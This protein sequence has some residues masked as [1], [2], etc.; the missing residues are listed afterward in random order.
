MA[1]Q[2]R[3]VR[4]FIS[5]TFR[6]M[7]A[8]RDHLVRFVF[9]RLREQ[10]LP[11]RIHLVDVDLRWGVTGEQDACEVCREIIDECRPRFLCMLGGRYGTIPEGR[12]L[13][14]T[15]DEVHFGILDADREKLYGL[16]HFR[17]GAATEKMDAPSPGSVREPRHSEKA[18]KLARLKRGIRAA[19]CKPFLY[20][21]R[22]D[23]E[24]QRLL[25][26][27]AFGDRVGR[28][29]LATIDDEF[30]VEPPAQLD[31][32]AEENAAMEAFVE[33]RGERF[34]L[35]SREAALE[36]LLAHAGATGGNGYVCLTGA[37]GS[38][39]SALLAHLS[40]HPTL[41]AQP[42]ILLIRHFVGAS[43]GSTDV[44]RTLRRLCHEL[45]AGCPDI[46]AE[47]PDDPE[48]LRAALAGFLRHA[49]ASR[50]V[51]ILLDG[52]D[53][54]DPASHSA[55]LHW[56][57]QDLPQGA[58]VI[59]SALD[60][61]ALE[62]LRRLC[63]PRE[64]ELKP[65]TA[66]D[67]GA[68][69]EQFRRRY[70]KQF[71]PDQRAA[72]LAKTDAGTPLYLL[73][74]LEELRTL[75]TYEEIA[76]RIAGLPATTQELFAWILKRLENDDGFRDAAGRRVGRELVSR[77]A[78]LLGASR[79]GLSHH[80]L[81]DLLDPGDPQG[82]VAAL[83]HLL[84]PYLMR[85]GELLD[86][87][88]GQLKDAVGKRY[89]SDEDERRQ[90]HKAIADY[91]ETRWRDAD[92]HALNELP[93]HL[94]KLGDLPL[95]SR[96]VRTGFLE[97]K[98]DALGDA[99]SL[100]D[101]WSI[102]SVLAK[103]G[104]AWWD[105]L[106]ACANSYCSLAE[107]VR[108]TSGTIEAAIR[109]GDVPRAMAILEAEKDD[110]HKGPVAL[111]AS[112]LLAN[113]GHEAAAEQLRDWAVDI[114]R[115]SSYSQTQFGS[116][117]L[118]YALLSE[119]EAARSQVPWAQYAKD[120]LGDELPPMAASESR[121]PEAPTRE[122]VP[123]RYVL[124][125]WLASHNWGRLTFVPI[126]G[127]S[128]F[129]VMLAVH[130]VWNMPFV[131]PTQW[132]SFWDAGTRIVI[133]ILAALIPTWLVRIGL[134]KV[135]A[136]VLKAKLPRLRELL[137]GLAGGFELAAPHRQLV[138]AARVARFQY[139]LHEAVGQHAGDDIGASVVARMM[140]NC[141]RADD[142]ARLIWE[143]TGMGTLACGAVVHELL[144]LDP[145]RRKV[146]LTQVLR[147]PQLAKDKK[148]LFRIFDGAGSCDLDPAVL[149]Q[150]LRNC[151]VRDF[152]GIVAALRRLPRRCLARA[153]LAGAALE[154]RERNN[155]KG[156]LARFHLLRR[157]LGRFRNICLRAIPQALGPT[158]PVW[159]LVLYTPSILLVA[160]WVP[161][162]ALGMLLAL[163]VILGLPDIISQGCDPYGIAR[164]SRRG[165][166]SKRAEDIE[167]AIQ[168]PGGGLLALKA[169]RRIAFTLLARE[170]IIRGR[171]DPE[172]HSPYLRRFME[173]LVPVLLRQG[174]L[175][176]RGEAV[177]MAMADRRLLNAALDGARLI[178]FN[179]ENRVFGETDH[180]RQL[181]ASLPLPVW[182]NLALM[183]AL[184]AS[185]TLLWLTTLMTVAPVA[186]AGSLRS[187][188]FW[189]VL[190]FCIGLVIMQHIWRKGMPPVITA[191]VICGG[192]AAC[193]AVVA[194]ST[195]WAIAVWGVDV[196]LGSLFLTNVLAPE[197]IAHWRGANLVYPSR[198]QLWRQR[199]SWVGVMM[200]AC[201][202]L[203]IGPTLSPW[204]PLLVIP[205]AAALI[206]W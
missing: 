168:K 200:V 47:I 34:V 192:F 173:L 38:G 185:G 28:D 18:A 186:I 63:K 82:N 160:M 174:L 95:L 89:L 148:N 195:D 56:L 142:A 206:C 116:G 106:V 49:C 115:R 107:R 146:I 46:T 90:A 203:G 165:G 135:C 97:R 172:T 114:V 189:E 13:S 53:Q 164:T 16:F 134:A 128:A 131:I 98:A 59:L 22:W 27:K 123:M 166:L 140:R 101:A 6:D 103:T 94:L 102:A 20:R 196:V 45:K 55:G 52:V 44:R 127:W 50:R 154:E 74:A 162:M 36:E 79:H 61:P 73:A 198:G 23:A 78:A 178:G 60:G 109:R 10:L 2:W 85:R 35:G 199:F 39:K 48:R 113:A 158:E 124:C 43:P 92:T 136:K 119:Q 58:R 169:G 108:G 112:V 143:A 125:A 7:Q 25:G 139:M 3:T 184:V 17:H 1:A 150:Y 96:L 120:S 15:A 141:V 187:Y 155:P 159:W 126:W 132:G 118:V 204:I 68:I 202:F 40:R 152:R 171:L 76:Q 91:F 181:H 105:D 111:A 100:T 37:P 86:F 193:S 19:K 33:E 62:E 194:R 30:G 69:I 122:T 42:S 80:E 104:A 99:D 11:R 157:T 21:P 66:D 87:Y 129:A 183:S 26:L 188:C 88:H 29:I 121:V 175:G 170:I 70:R 93:Y 176:N 51:V 137:A 77:F 133:S 191:I 180:D 149:H 12:E 31:E 84:R 110:A 64:I 67:G 75:G 24:E 190:A 32:F 197:F 9:P 138:I 81:A 71:E 153:V 130:Y 65:L 8:E 4:V 156:L 201:V 83:L 177:L 161:V 14:I 144:R 54:F 205:W 163:G 145:Q 5:S 72:L 57:P 117:C 179:R 41:H 182:R 167:E 147:W 151:G